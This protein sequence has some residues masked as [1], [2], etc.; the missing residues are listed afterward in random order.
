M[1]VYRSTFVMAALVVPTIA[2]HVNPATMRDRTMTALR[3]AEDSE[4]TFPSMDG[5]FSKKDDVDFD[6]ARDCASHFGKCTVEEMVELK[7]GEKKT[8]DKTQENDIQTCGLTLLVLWY[9]CLLL[10]T[11]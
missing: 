7:D 10:F 9:L 8:K 11:F 6:R 5:P 3:V 2:F 4:M 1:T